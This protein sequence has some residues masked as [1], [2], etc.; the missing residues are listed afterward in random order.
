MLA[1]TLR[2]RVRAGVPG[3]PCRLMTEAC[4]WGSSSECRF[5]TCYSIP[6]PA[7]PAAKSIASGSS[8]STRQVSLWAGERVCVKLRC[9]AD[10]RL[11]RRDR[12]RNRR[13]LLRLRPGRAAMLPCG[14]AV[15]TFAGDLTVR[16]NVFGACSG[17]SVSLGAAVTGVVTFTDNYFG[18]DEYGSPCPPGRSLSWGECLFWRTPADRPGQRHSRP[19]WR[20]H[21]A[22]EA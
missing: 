16:D 20:S 21:Q 10:P 13:Q 22:V 18:V 14:T 7:L 1:L 6:A 17:L 9:S 3:V 11:A 2:Q 8:A 15:A 12:R 5:P 19:R 4:W